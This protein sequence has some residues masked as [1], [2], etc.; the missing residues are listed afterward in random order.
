MRHR[1]NPATYWLALFVFFAAFCGIMA[2]VVM[3]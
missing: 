3:K 2:F 1:D